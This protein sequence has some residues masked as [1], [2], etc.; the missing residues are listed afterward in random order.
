MKINCSNNN[1][2]QQQ[3][4]STTPNE[5]VMKLNSQQESF[6]EAPFWA[7]FIT[8]LGY[9]ILNIFGWFRDSLRY[10]GLEDKKGAADNNPAGFV[11]LFSEYECFYTRNLY[12]RIRDCFNRPIC[13]VPGANIDIIERVSD[14]FNWTFKRSGKLIPALNL[15]SYNYLGFA[16]NNG[17]CANDSIRALN[18]YS[19]ATC[20][21]RQELGTL[22][23]HKEL[24]EQ[25][26]E[27]LGVESS[28]V[29]GMGFATNSTNIPN[30]VGKGC[31]ILSD[32]LNHASLVL[33]A[34]LSGA[35]IKVF[36]HNDMQDLENILKESIITGQTKTKR[37]WKKILIIVEGIYR[38]F[39]CFV[40]IL[41]E[42]NYFLIIKYGR[43]NYKFTKNS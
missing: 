12:T 16:E 42:F 10:F 25:V 40:L 7:A 30:L 32:E 9:L 36:K 24:E 19:V 5:P 38:F 6:E 26:A 43:F 11:P 35:N 1:N 31:L 39:F 14:D 41:K 34:R 17:K 20:C 29:F 21:S 4:N 33:G 22:K 3:H 2:K 28:I 15:G 23:L 37:P 27:F 8:Y 18:N 13:S